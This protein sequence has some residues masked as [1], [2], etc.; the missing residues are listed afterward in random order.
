MRD[1]A[2]RFLCVSCSQPIEV[3][4]AWASRTVLCPFCRATVSAPPT[5]TLTDLSAVPT[6]SPVSS[7]LGTPPLRPRDPTMARAQGNPVAVVAF[8]L[9]C[10]AGLLGILG[11]ALAASH[12]LEMQEFT[13][14][15]QAGAAQSKSGMQV[16]A[17]YMKDHG[18]TAPT[19]LVGVGLLS[20]ASLLTLLAAFICAIIGLFRPA[21]RGFAVTALVICGLLLGFVILSNVA[22]AA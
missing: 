21:R 7:N 1:M 22:G 8:V 13:E 17:E 19:W 18:G 4:D 14:R 16:M 11:I 15:I 10:I 9:T 5:S 2:I 3:D 20:M 6:A 12:S